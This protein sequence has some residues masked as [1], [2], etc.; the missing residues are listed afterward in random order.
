LADAT[1]PNAG[2]PS[3]AYERMSPGWQLIDDIIAGPATVRAA[4]ERYLPKLKAEEK[5]YS[6]TEYRRRLMATPWR[7]EFVDILQS[8]A[9]K[10]FGKEV[11]LVDGASPRI[12]ELAE[13]ID[14]RGANLTQFARGAF[15]NGIA[16][17]CHAILVDFPT[18][19]DVRTI[20][21]EK[22]AGARPYWVSIRVEDILALYTAFVDGKEVVT[23][24]RI[25]E[26]TIER[27]G[28]GETEVERV[29]VLE[30]NR[31]ELW[32]KDKDAAGKVEYVL[33]SEGM[34]TLGVVPLALFW[35][36]E[37]EGAQFVRPPLAAIADMQ[38]EI[39]RA[40]GRK[41]E[42]LTYAGHPMLK[43]VGFAKPKDG[44][45]TVGPK[46]VL[47]APPGSEG[48]PTDWDFI[49]PDPAVL[50]EIRDDVTARIDDIRRLGMQ[51]L[52][53]KSGSVT[54]TATSVEAAK[55]HST[56][57]AWALG[58]KDCLEQ[59]LVF[60]ALWLREDAMAEVVV[61]TDF[62][63]G[64]ANQVAIDALH[65]ARQLKEISRRAYIEGLMRFGVLAADF[66]IEADEE[67]IAEEMEG[68]EPEVT[69]DPVTG[70]EID[71]ATGQPKQAAA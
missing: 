4:A 46:A 67:L 38:M 30:P 16:K 47:F 27:D 64:E 1:K 44:V 62:M 53:Q 24:V 2:T 11:S 42:I 19:S 52:T 17:G 68:L 23:H 61:N 14:A 51:P 5:D 7:P 6:E 20:A 31:W 21:D 25:R 34:L 41:E 48:S 13:D 63:A 57:E 66:D 36:G 60:T 9:S 70:Q 45:I 39:Y 22:R 65:K 33:E 69:I 71:P 12:K 3:S 55:A 59:A 10:P 26:C 58:L 56:V 43:A 49:Q 28:F 54:A 29:R 8:L 15:R 40:L 32:R 37:R 18:M 50:T 35:T